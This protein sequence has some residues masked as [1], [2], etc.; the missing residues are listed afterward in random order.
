MP[1]KKKKKDKDELTPRQ[2]QGLSAL[3][4]GSTQGD[5]AKAAKVNVETVR[6]WMKEDVFRTELRLSMERFR[7]QFESRMLLVANNATIVVQKM[8]NDKSIDI[9]AKGATLALNAAVRLSTRYKELQVEG[10]IPPPVPMIMLPVGT[11]Q[12]WA[13]QKALP[14]PVNPEDIV[15]VTPTKV[16]K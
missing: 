10:Y 8:L 6:G 3:S 7:Q 2:I 14:A 11:V 9:Q 16:K 13:N 4:V 12:P 1:A 5:A 15:D